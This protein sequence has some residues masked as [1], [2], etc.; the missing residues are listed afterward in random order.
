MPAPTSSSHASRRQREPNGEPVAQ[1]STTAAAIR[2]IN[3]EIE[4]PPNFSLAV[5]GT[6]DRK[7]E[8][9]WRVDDKAGVRFL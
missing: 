5:R 6:A 3:S 4:I 2:L 9:C 1:N 8:L 7:C